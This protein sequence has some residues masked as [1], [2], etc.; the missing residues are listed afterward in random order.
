MKFFT[1]RS[2]IQKIVIAILTILVLT[3]AI[4]KPVSAVTNLLLS[5]VITLGT[6][7]LD[8]IQH[9]LEWA[10]LGE[11]SNFMKDISDTSSYPQASNSKD[12]CWANNGVAYDEIEG[13]LWGID[14]VNIPY[15][16]YT[17]EE[18]FAN[19]VPALD[20]NFINPSVKVNTG[21]AKKDEEW[22]ENHNIAMQ[23]QPVISSWY[24]AIR[25]LALVA[26][27][28]VLVYL[29]I[30]M[31]ITSVAADKAKYKKMIMDW[32][33]GICL[34][35]VLHYIMSFALTMSE[36]ITSMLGPNT[37]QSINVKFINHENEI[38]FSGNLMSYVRF[39]I[40]SNDTST[41]VGFFFLYLMLVIYS[42]RFTWVYL[43]R[44][45]NMAFLTIIAPFVA[46]T[47]PI[48][49]VSDGSAQ[50]F[51]MWIK[52]FSFNAVLQPLHLLLYKVLLGSAVSLAVINPLYAIVCL[53]FIL[54]AE[55]LLK[56][57]FGF[58]KAGA[59]TVGS[60]AGAA[61]VSA[62]ASKA[63]MG[64]AKKLVPGG[65]NGS[66]KVRTN[67]KY[68][69]DG[70]SPNAPKGI[71]SLNKEG[72]SGLPPVSVG[73]GTEESN[74]QFPEGSG[75]SNNN[76][77]NGGEQQPKQETLDDLEQQRAELYNQGYTDDSEEIS[78]IN[79]RIEDG[80]FATPQQAPDTSGSPNPEMT[81]AELQNIGQDEP[82]TVGSL[83][84]ND[85]IRMKN[86]ATEK[87]DAISTGAK[88][89]KQR[90]FTREG[91]KETGR[92]LSVG[93]YKRIRG[94]V[95]TAPTAIY[96]VARNGAKLTARA[97]AGV[98]LGAT[99]GVIAATNGNGEQS[100]AALTGGFGV[101]F[102][103]GDNIFEATVG[104]V[105]KDANVKE[106]YGA[107]KYGSKTDYRNAMAD[108]EFLKSQ[109]FNDYYEKNFKG[110]KTKKEVREA[111]KSYREAGITDNKTIKTAMALEDKYKEAAGYDGNDKML[112]R[113][114]Q[115]IVQTKDGI[116]PRAFSDPVKKAKEI[117]KLER[118]FTN[119][120]DSKERT[121]KAAQLFQ[122][123]QDFDD[124]WNF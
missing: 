90:V 82:E 111:F 106:T 67:D 15:I 107:S 62:L 12:A 32:I 71:D 81:E 91:W 80:D 22:N 51:N 88:N 24:I 17:P 115:E 52:E 70:K 3:F 10:L 109:E 104:K 21:D 75:T 101:G 14:E 11:T 64:G 50:A 65:G 46:L 20:V 72:A 118:F 112:R 43:K 47:Y 45:V 9:I 123:Y 7:M 54:A 13:T 68:K 40:Q 74:S 120:N 26:L 6:S 79:Q 63:L 108:K 29:G 69:R 56:S 121:K 84:A 23:L 86:W 97:A 66:G 98:A 92:Q 27:L 55:K 94:A 60:L 58:N 59:G 119:V 16:R 48:D 30:R 36:V 103:N 83:W 53:G 96:K 41:G 113:N 116:N 57:M 122:G 8:G 73:S 4:P 77:A 34:L 100:M 44:V 61:G 2:V 76:N 18:I 105:A 124:L 1:N 42:I 49:K 87:K 31:L 99:A 89:I 25:T 39:M 5:P 33:V 19:R 110:K 35:F 102:A 28:S 37:T 95:T 117:K 114:V 38:S 85:K 78:A 93:A